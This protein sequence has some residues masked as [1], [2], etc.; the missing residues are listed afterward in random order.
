VLNNKVIWEFFSM[1]TKRNKGI[2]KSLK[3]H[4]SWNSKKSPT[5]TTEPYYQTTMLSSQTERGDKAEQR[6]CTV[7]P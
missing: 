2:S 5:T 7:Y 1:L 6:C 3:E 4:I